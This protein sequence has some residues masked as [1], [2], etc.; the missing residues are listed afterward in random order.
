[1]LVSTQRRAMCFHLSAAGL[2]G[3]AF[4]H[5]SGEVIAQ[6]HDP[7]RQLG[8]RKGPK[9]ESQRNSRLDRVTLSGWWVEGIHTGWCSGSMFYLP[10]ASDVLS[11]EVLQVDYRQPLHQ[12]LPGV[13]GL[14]IGSRGQ[15]IR[16]LGFLTY[17]WMLCIVCVCV[18]FYL[19]FQ[20]SC[21]S[22][23]CWYGGS[24]P[25]PLGCDSNKLTTRLLP[26]YLIPGQEHDWEIVMQD[27]GI[28]F[29][30]GHLFQSKQRREKKNG[31]GW[32]KKVQGLRC[33]FA[34]F[35]LRWNMCEKWQ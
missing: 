31:G 35:V 11:P 28:G 2:L 18:Q 22:T 15:H 23:D 33:A 10:P 20:A 1:M 3:R 21:A 9:K 17:P 25:E 8:K 12:G 29:G 14:G 5:H 34:I 27:T 6:G 30:W 16:V 7:D 32:G 24:N 4:P 13:R 26:D 19:H